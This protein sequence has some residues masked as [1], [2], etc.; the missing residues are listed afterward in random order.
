MFLLVRDEDPPTVAA[1]INAFAD[2]EGLEPIDLASQAE[3][4]LSMLSVLS[5]PRVFVSQSDD[6]VFVAGLE[7]LDIAEPD[8]WGTAVST[9]CE[10]EVIAIAPVEGGVRT[11]VFD[12][13]ELDEQVDVPLDPSGRTAAPLLADFAPNEESRRELETG[14][15]ASRVEELLD[16]L[17]RCLGVTAK[18]EDAV[19]LAFQ[20]PLADAESDEDEPALVVEALTAASLDGAVGGPVVSPHGNVFGVQLAGVAEHEGVRLVIE[21]DAL[22][23]ASIDRIDV[24]LRVRGGHELTHRVVRPEGASGA[25][26][27]ELPD[28]FLERVRRGPPEVDPSDLFATMQ[29][30]MSAGDEQVLNTLT[31]RPSGTG[32]RAG[33]G[34]LVLRASPLTGELAAGEAAIPVRVRG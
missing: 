13:G 1:A 14:V 30:L 27:V 33:E 34:A 3:N 11:W 22:E 20:D 19:I 2:E 10:T 18:G 26:V 5:G 16:G 17:L 4:P 15:A 24:W 6:Q 8:E 9:A 25:I 23:L 29:R 31:V 21:G 32:V 12:G 7:S 28:A